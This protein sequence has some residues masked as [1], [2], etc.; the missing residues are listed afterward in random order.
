MIRLKLKGLHY[1]YAMVE[2]YHLMNEE[3]T[4]SRAAII[5]AEETDSVVKIE[6]DRTE[7][8]F[9]NAPLELDYLVRHQG[10]KLSPSTNEK[11]RI[12]LYRRDY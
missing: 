9:D 8:E 4:S 10:F 2:T 3:L 5:A 1:T 6:D 12:K 11:E 7:V